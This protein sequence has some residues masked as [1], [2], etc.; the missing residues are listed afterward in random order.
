MMKEPERKN[1]GTRRIEIGHKH[2]RERQGDEGRG[3]RLAEDCYI[4][5]F[6]NHLVIPYSGAYEFAT[7]TEGSQPMPALRTS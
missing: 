5:L 3:Q 7:L 4:D 6:L 2:E 1:N